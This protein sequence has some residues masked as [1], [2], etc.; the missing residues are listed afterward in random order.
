MHGNAGE[1]IVLDHELK[2]GSYLA[3]REVDYWEA[4]ALKEIGEA[5]GRRSSNGG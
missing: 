5:E 2:T 4:R 1:Y 3:S